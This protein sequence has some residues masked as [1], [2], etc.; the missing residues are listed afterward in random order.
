[1]LNN[2]VYCCSLYILKPM[3]II[4]I[5]MHISSDKR[6]Q[7][8]VYINFPR[9]LS[10]LPKGSQQDAKI[11]YISKIHWLY[12]L[13]HILNRLLLYCNVY[14]CTLTFLSSGNIL[15][16]A[17]GVA[18]IFKQ[19]G[20]GKTSQG[21]RR[22]GGGGGEPTE[23][24]LFL[25][26]TP[27]SLWRFIAC[28]HNSRSIYWISIHALINN[29]IKGIMRSYDVLNRGGG[30]KQA[31]KRSDRGGGGESTIGILLLFL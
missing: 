27:I 11:W 18:M 23:G 30:T 5:Y 26:Y 4:Q 2:V 21:T 17:T 22:P 14:T 19:G 25:F 1:M 3:M 13:V 12:C 28:N 15:F 20:G 7:V 24:I 29:H 10:R 16:P 31:R 9:W 8:L 6:N